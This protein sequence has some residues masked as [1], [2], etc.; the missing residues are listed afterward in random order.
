MGKLIP[1]TDLENE[2]FIIT[3]S[4]VCLTDLIIKDSS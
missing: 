3:D 1:I 2:S 4:L